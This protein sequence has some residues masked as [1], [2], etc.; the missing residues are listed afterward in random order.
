[1][2]TAQSRGVQP[3]ATLIQHTRTGLRATVQP[4]RIKE[5]TTELFMSEIHECENFEF[6]FHTVLNHFLP[7]CPHIYLVQVNY[8]R[9]WIKCLES[10]ASLSREDPPL[11]PRCLDMQGCPP[12]WKLCSRLDRGRFGTRECLPSCM[13]AVVLTRQ[14]L[15]MSGLHNCQNVLLRLPPLNPTKD[16]AF[17]GQGAPEPCRAHCSWR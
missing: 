11:Q 1:M 6:K 8:E 5:N 10:F 17:W 7:F 16:E 13:R 14:Q 9:T 15:C 3:G 4:M 12:G 2:W